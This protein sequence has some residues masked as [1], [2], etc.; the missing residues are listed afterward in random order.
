MAFTQKQL[1]IWFLNP[2][3]PECLV[4]ELTHHCYALLVCLKG[5]QWSWQCWPDI[6]CDCRASARL[7]SVPELFSL[8]L[9]FLTLLCKLR[10]LPLKVRFVLHN[11][12]AHQ[13]SSAGEKSDH[14]HI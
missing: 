13:T 9:L 5:H 4:M 14:Y 1:N 11:C 10:C 7:R 3:I 8:L 2:N 12:S 6:S